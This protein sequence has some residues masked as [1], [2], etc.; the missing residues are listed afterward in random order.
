MSGFTFSFIGPSPSYLQT[1][2]TRTLS[3]GT[4]ATTIYT[5]A[6]F[7]N[8]NSAYLLLVSGTSGADSSFI[9]LVITNFEA[10][11]TFTVI[12]SSKGNSPAA[13]TY[14]ITNDATNGNHLQLAMSSGSYTINVVA[15]KVSNY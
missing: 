2:F 14:S 12:A 3:V 10:P 5:S 7:T 11:S 9:D 1:D 13:R 8:F 4:S 6:D 15:F